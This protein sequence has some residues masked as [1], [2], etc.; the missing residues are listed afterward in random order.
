MIAV[1]KANTEWKAMAAMLQALS[2]DI[3]GLMDETNKMPDS[4]SQERREAAERRIQERR[5]RPAP[6]T[7]GSVIGFILLLFVVM[8][9]VAYAASRL[10]QPVRVAYMSSRSGNYEIY[11]VDRDGG[12]PQ[13]LTNHEAQDGVPGWSSTE[14]AIA[15]FST[16]GGD[17]VALYRMD[18]KGEDVRLLDD[19]LPYAF[20]SPQWSP[21]GEWIAIE[22]GTEEAIDVYLVSS[23][24]GEARNLT[25][26]PDSLDR[27]GA[28][29]PD[30]SQLIIVSN[31]E[32]QLC[33]FLMSIDTGSVVRLTDPA[34]GSATPAWSPDGSSIAFTSEQ[35]GDIDI[36]IMDAD[37][38]HMK[39]LTTAPGF[40]GFPKWAPDGSQIAF[41]TVRDENPEIYRINVDGSGLQNLTNNVSFDS[42]EGDFSWSP[43]GKQILFTSDRN[44]DLD[45]FV[46]DANGTNLLNLSND[47][48]ED[49]APIWVP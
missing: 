16:R 29:S 2:E 36:Y 43:D 3:E 6:F 33:L 45:I 22:V 46:M 41:M 8:V 34:Y 18:E 20:G 35:D 1:G 17:S 48:G 49:F 19:T 37:G 23:A 12:N 27:F 13:N 38:G 9:A 25:Q 15:F 14:G 7:L 40:D 11:L 21:T 30:G 31:R 42:A 24:S 39:R 47:L 4:M 32:G 5:F 26:S 10:F 44:G 28:W